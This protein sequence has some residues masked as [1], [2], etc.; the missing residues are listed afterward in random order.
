MNQIY[1]WT[2]RHTPRIMMAVALLYYVG[3]V[4]RLIVADQEM[5]VFAN[6]MM[7]T[8]VRL[9]TIFLVLVNPMIPALVMLFGAAILWRWDIYVARNEAAE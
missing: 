3:S 2:M 7:S 5:N 9:R 4:I 6:D 1:T 8:G